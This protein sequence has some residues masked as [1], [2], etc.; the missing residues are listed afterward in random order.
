MLKVVI[1]GSGNAFAHGNQYQSAHYIEF[2][3]KDKLLL[4][5]GPAILQAVQ[6]AEINIDDLQYLFITHLH[7]DHLAGI[8]FLLLH[9]KYILQRFDNPLQIIGPIGLT[10]QLDFLLKG[11]YPNLLDTGQLF[12]IREI[13]IGEELTVL[14]S[15]TVKSYEAFHI[16]NAMGYTISKG[17][18]KVIY[19][20]DN[21]L[22]PE[23]LEHFDNGTV[24]IHE[25]NT[26]NSTAGGHTS[27]T[28]MSDHIDAI[29][30]KVGKVIAVHTSLDVRNEPE[31]TFGQKI[32]RAR[33]GSTFHFN[34]KGRLYQM[35]L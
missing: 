24:L 5:C 4:D 16:P 10:K 15:I 1:L 34:E 31:T 20:G 17:E 13:N 21:E 2:N 11:N 3:E 18:L 12:E 29:L 8:P 33:D 19:S 22:K 14:D 32:I 23:Q 9:Y 25:M 26:M 28:L 30:Q 7:G 6:A 27:W 35:V